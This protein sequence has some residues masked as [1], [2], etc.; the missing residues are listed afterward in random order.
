MV[1]PADGEVEKSHSASRKAIQALCA[2]TSNLRVSGAFFS[3]CRIWSYVALS[4][5]SDFWSALPAHSL[6]VAWSEAFEQSSA[7]ATGD[8][9]IPMSSSN[10]VGRTGSLHVC[11][12]L[13]ILPLNGA[14]RSPGWAPALTSG[15]PTDAA[16]DPG[17][18]TAAWRCR[19]RD[20]AR[21]GCAMLGPL[22]ALASA[23][24]AST[25]RRITG[26]PPQRAP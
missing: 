22:L 16:R 8:N 21:A 24:R 13:A 7:R 6:M 5:A 20:A 23:T 3:R 14:G 9:V 4:S 17:G 2:P 26:T 19:H 10:I 15:G 1:P 11:F 25:M 18:A 12:A